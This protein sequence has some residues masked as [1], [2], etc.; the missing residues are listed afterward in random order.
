[1][2]SA[3]RS[4]K[5]IILKNAKHWLWRHFACC[6]FLIASTSLQAKIGNDGESQTILFNNLPRV[7]LLVKEQYVDPKRINPDAMLASILESLESRITKLVVSLPKTLEKA[8]EQAKNVEGTITKLDNAKPD[9]VKTPVAKKEDIKAPQEELVLDLGGVKKSFQFESQR[10]IWGMVF[11]L[12]DI[13]RFVEVEA[14]KQRLTEKSGLG[15]EP[16][17]WEKIETA[18]INA[19]LSTLDPHSVYLEPKYARDLTLTTEGKFGGIGIVMG[20]ERKENYLQVISP[21]DGTPAALAGMKAKDRIMKID[22]DSAVNMDLN[23]A[24]NLLRG[25][26]GSAVRI[27]VRRQNVAK[28]IE[29][30]LKRAIIKVDSVAYALLDSNVGYL[31][32]KA[33]QGN[34]AQDVKN[35]ILSMKKSSKNSMNGLILDLRGNPGGLLREA[36]DVSNLF[37]DSGEVV[38]TQGARPDSRQVELASAGELDP[39]LKIVV[40]ADGGSASASEIV[41]SAIKNGG[42]NNG[43]GIVVGERTF[44]K[45][46]VQML[47]DFPTLPKP[48]PEGKKY[49]AT[50]SEKPDQPAALKLTIAEYFG[51]NDTSMQTIG[52]TPDIGLAPVHVGKKEEIKLFP[53]TGT[54]EVDLEGHLSTEKQIA[55]GLDEKPL[56]NFE[57]LAP[58]PDEEIEYGKLDLVKL[59]KD[60]AVLVASEFLKES[61]GILRSNLLANGGS[62]RDRLQK[63]ESKKIT[64]ALKKYGIDWSSG[65]SKAKNPVTATVTHN[66][67]AMAGNKLKVAVKVKNTSTEPLYQ[68]HGITHSKTPLFD[69]KEFLF[70]KL[71]PGQELERFVEFEIPKDV[72][73]RRD[74]MG[75]EFRD[76]HREKIGEIDIPLQVT[77]LARPRFAHM[78]YVDDSET[79]NGDGKV[80]N[81][82]EVKLVV[83]LKNVGH[84]KAFEPTVL[85]RNESG[86]KV[87][88]KQGRFQAKELL[89]N[90]EMGAEFSFRVK[91]PTDKVNFEIQIFDNEMH[92]LWRD[93]IAVQVA[94]PQTTKSGAHTLVLQGLESQLYEEP[95]SESKSIATLKKGIVLSS[96]KET[97]DFWLVKV[98]NNLTGF[99]KKSDVKQIAKNSVEKPNTNGLYQINYD[100]I[101]TEVALR[102]GDNSGLSKSET[103]KLAVEINN[104]NRLS[105]I[106]LYV[107]G[108]KVLYRDVVNASGQEKLE[109]LIYLKPG[110]NIVTLFA[111]EDT[112]YGQRENMTIYYDQDGKVVRALNPS[113]K[114]LKTN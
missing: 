35:A 12:R 30:T 50:A 90:A 72:V 24:V 109:H 49:T 44:G 106:L 110:V 93:K 19:M 2:G 94:K 103:G 67:G 56:F 82:E 18:A 11:L 88:L 112:T 97:K 92:D 33:F 59:K 14:K 20:V 69:Q 111:G 64:D 84:G 79:G 104:V 55:L 66:K 28:E 9:P 113:V 13:F 95:R 76:Y 83:W 65:I 62:I 29:F 27:S 36:V 58:K 71:M 78:V 107:N 74:L 61:F 91:E 89:P 21:I 26:P 105:S 5:L 57:Y 6:F 63:S 46:S 77:G 108:K 8:R 87:F 81:G 43:R 73:T 98:R 51:P 60:F 96:I 39:K 10:S 52:V 70:G 100:R 25:K 1:M 17:D 31:R 34:T 32:I 48:D 99:V 45:G 80:Q 41:A 68:L 7:A 102:F 114:A 42:S 40:L 23:D 3:R 86:S 37:L 54:R 75:L 38:S 85:L 47:F 15:E 22:D 16:I 101:P 53:E 4:M